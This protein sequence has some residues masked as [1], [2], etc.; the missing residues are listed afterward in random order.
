[1]KKTERKEIEP[2]SILPLEAQEILKDAAR[3]CQNGHTLYEKEVILDRAYRIVK[4]KWP[5][6]FRN[7]GKKP[8]PI[9]DFVE[10]WR[11]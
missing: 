6:Y 3:E 4:S 1:M 2:N 7:E 5:Y 9:N 11:K 10:G 8:D